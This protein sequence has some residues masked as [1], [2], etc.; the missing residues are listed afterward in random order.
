M[1]IVLDYIRGRIPAAKFKKEWYSNPAIGQWLD[2]LIDLKSP[3]QEEWNTLPYQFIRLAIHKHYGGSVVKFIETS[4]HFHSQ[5]PNTPK[6]LD[7][8]WHFDSIAAIIVVAYPEIIPTTYYE[9][10][11]SYHRNAVGDYLGGPEVEEYIDNILESF[12]RDMGK[13]KRTKA[14]KT[15][16]KSRFHISGNQY[17]R[18]AQEAEWPMGTQ[19]PMM[20]VS[21]KR[22]GE[23]VVFTFQDVDTGEIRMIEQ[24]N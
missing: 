22:T 21:Q 18:W 6:W 14:A 19:S 4:D 9:E 7:I 2:S 5:H 3:P 10:E 23:Q 11:A 17:P 12:P 13:T 24:Y 8:K 1:Q 16:L 15:E 20:F